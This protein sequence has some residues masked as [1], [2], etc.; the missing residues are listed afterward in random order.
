MPRK[1]KGKTY[2]Y[3]H[4]H[5]KIFAKHSIWYTADLW[6]NGKVFSEPTVVAHKFNAT[7]GL[8]SI[9]TLGVL[10]PDTLVLCQF[11][12]LTVSQFL[13]SSVERSTVQVFFSFFFFYSCFLFHLCLTLLGHHKLHV[14]SLPLPLIPNCVLHLTAIFTPF[15]RALKVILCQIKI[16]NVKCNILF[17][18]HTL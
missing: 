1:R 12:L 17:F 8:H 10:L 2:I 5:F 6:S 16:F 3:T 11:A 15:C 14:F 18:K 4:L 13:F 7:S 9:K